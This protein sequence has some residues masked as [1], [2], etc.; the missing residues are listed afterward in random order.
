MAKQATTNVSPGY[1]QLVSRMERRRTSCLEESLLIRVACKFK[2]YSTH[3]NV[4][5]ANLHRGKHI[6]SISGSPLNPTP[7]RLLCRA[8]GL[9]QHPSWMRRSKL[10]AIGEMIYLVAVLI[11]IRHLRWRQPTNHTLAGCRHHEGENYYLLKS[12]GIHFADTQ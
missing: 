9:L 11:R 4:V 3:Q 5:D 1:T 2:S 10:S 7:R 12:A 6:I 8:V